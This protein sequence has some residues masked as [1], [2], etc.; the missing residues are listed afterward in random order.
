V[1]KVLLLTV[2]LAASGLSLADAPAMPIETLQ[3]T[4]PVR[5]VAYLYE[6]CKDRVLRRRCTA[7]VF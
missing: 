3:A 6:S 5:S 2:A 1:W 4:D 7:L